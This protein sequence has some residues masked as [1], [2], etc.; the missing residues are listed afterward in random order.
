MSLRGTETASAG[1]GPCAKPMGPCA[2]KGPCA[3]PTRPCA[4]K[5]PCAKPMGPFAKTGPCAG[6]D[7]G[8]VNPGRKAGRGKGTRVESIR[9]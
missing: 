2:K 1:T 3:K 8:A 6:I 4:K 7:R 5:G 9:T